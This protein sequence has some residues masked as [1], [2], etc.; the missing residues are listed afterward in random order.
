MAQASLDEN[1]ILRIWKGFRMWKQRDV[2]KSYKA[3]KKLYSYVHLQRQLGTA[4]IYFRISQG[5][6]RHRGE[7]RKV[8]GIKRQELAIK[9]HF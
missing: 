8:E 7:G 2:L 1:L 9:S 4:A 6:A 3:D 5:F